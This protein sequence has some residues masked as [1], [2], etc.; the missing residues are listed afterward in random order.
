MKRCIFVLS[1]ILISSL[2]YAQDVHIKVQQIWSEDSTYCSFTSLAQF[3]G[4]YYC[5]F[6]EA[7]QHH[8]DSR[9]PASMGKARIIVSKDGKKWK[10]VTLIAKEGCDLRDPKLSVMPDGKLMV[11]MGGNMCEGRKIKSQWTYVAFSEDGEHFSELQ[12]VVLDSQITG[13][14]EWIWHVTWHKGTGYGVIYGSDFVTVK[15]TDGIHYDLLGRLEQPY[16]GSEATVDFLSDGT[17]LLI[18]RR[19]NPHEAV[20]GWAVSKPP[21]TDYEWKDMNIVLGGPDMIVL[22]D[23]T[24]ILG[25][26][27]LYSSEK[28]MLFKGGA[29][30]NFEEVC[31]LPSG[32]DDNSYT[33]MIIVGKELWVS[34]YSRHGR[35]KAAIY[36]AK[37]PLSMFTD[38]RSNKYYETIW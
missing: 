35:K 3:K 21:Y 15:T 23:S 4:K 26:R 17:M 5:S 1:T 25:S 12:P 20:G 16:R 14:R 7:Y 30:G 33:G 13:N 32:G 11:I 8:G 38:G 37:M 28:T 34:Y 18:A 27:S 19:K 24:C 29:D 6:R 9:I 31:I 2:L 10:S 36:L 22:N